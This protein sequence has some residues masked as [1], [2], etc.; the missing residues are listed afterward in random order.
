M[1]A[2]KLPNLALLIRRVIHAFG[3]SSENVRFV[4]TSATIG[5]PE[6]PAGIHLREFLAQIAGV[7]IS[8][9]YLVSAN[10]Q[11]PTLPSVNESKLQPL[12][13]L[14]A[15]DAG[16]DESPNRYQALAGQAIAKKITSRFVSQ[17]TSPIARL[18]EVC[19][20][21]FGLGQSY[22]LAQ[23]QQALEW[24]D[25]VTS[26]VDTGGNP[27]LPLRAHLFHQTLSG[28]WCCADAQCPDKKGS[29]LDDPAWPFG[30]VFLGPRNHCTCGAP[31]Y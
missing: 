29:K 12:E 27:F 24:L 19:A 31:V 22:T 7:D 8:R 15:I 10:R 13:S 18:S 20:D 11:I 9:V 5:D 3:V 2:R 17:K 28:L 25:L 23:Q 16:Q 4:A 30:Q 6:G 26:T 1:S 14:C 21:I